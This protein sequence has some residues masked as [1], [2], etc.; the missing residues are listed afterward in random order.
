[1]FRSIGLLLLARPLLFPLVA[2]V[3]AC[4]SSSE[5]AV[6]V[7]IPNTDTIETPAAGVGVVALPYN[8]D[9]VLARLEA[10][11]GT[12]RP[13]TAAL[14]S[15]FARFR[16][17]FTAYTAAAYAVGQLRDSIDQLRQRLDS[18]PPGAPENPALIGRYRQLSDSLTVTERRTNR[19]RIELDRARAEFVGASES[20]RAAVRHW[21]DSTYRGYDS[22]VENLVRRSGRAAVTDTTGATGWASFVLPAG[23]WWIYARAWDT[24]DPNAEWYWNLPVSGDTMLL[25][26]RTGRRR[27]RY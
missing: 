24:S 8:R 17:P 26:S 7:S 16:G 18:L 3:A 19:A 11:A 25:S 21:E 22:I 5:V 27:P 13:H 14:D 9:S 2:V 10:R 6:R 23:R 4:R 1:M 12:K 20:L 15:L